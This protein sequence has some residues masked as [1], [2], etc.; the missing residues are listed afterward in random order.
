[1]RSDDEQVEAHLERHRRRLEEHEA[2]LAAARGTH[3]GSAESRRTTALTTD[4][5]RWNSKL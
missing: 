2:S 3:V 4:G 1:M 5:T